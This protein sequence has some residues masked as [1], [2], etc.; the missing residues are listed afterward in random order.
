VELGGERKELG[1]GFGGGGLKGKDAGGSDKGALTLW[2]LLSISTPP[3][4]SPALSTPLP[5]SFVFS[6][7]LFTHIGG[8][9]WAQAWGT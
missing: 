6:F 1:G 3:G 4:Y 9:Q 2:T 8:L 7:L 5:S